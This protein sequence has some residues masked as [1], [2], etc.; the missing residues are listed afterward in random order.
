MPG[1]VKTACWPQGF[2]CP[3]CGGQAHSEITSRGLLQYCACRRQTSL[4]AGTIFASTHLPLRLWFR[5]MYHLT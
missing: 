4:T 1:R 5:A 2:V 3:G